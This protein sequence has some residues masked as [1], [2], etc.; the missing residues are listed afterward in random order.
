MDIL[1]Q[2]FCLSRVTRSSSMSSSLSSSELAMTEPVGD[3]EFEDDKA[4]DSSESWILSMLFWRSRSIA[5][6]LV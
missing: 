2:F 4:E 3:E 6:F 1:L 5:F